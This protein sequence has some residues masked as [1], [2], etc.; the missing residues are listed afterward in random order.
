MPLP[1]VIG[2]VIVLDAIAR[3]HR[4]GWPSSS[5]PATDVIG[6]G[7]GSFDGRIGLW[8]LAVEVLAEGL[9][10]ALRL[11]GIVV[12]SGCRVSF[13]CDKNGWMQAECQAQSNKGC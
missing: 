5:M 2:L 10:G 4:L 11:W 8:C 12:R 3:R 13:P 7:A 6:F 9:R 1:D